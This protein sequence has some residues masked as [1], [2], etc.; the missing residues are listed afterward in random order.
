M[1]PRTRQDTPEPRALAASGKHHARSITAAAKRI[2]LTSA[3]DRGAIPRSTQQWQR[4]AW[5]VYDLLPDVKFAGRFLGSALSRLL[6]FPGLRVAADEP[7]AQLRDVLDLQDAMVAS[8]AD[9]P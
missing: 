9:L 1:A 6:L 8:N 2:D 5:N 7:L 3:K 4:D